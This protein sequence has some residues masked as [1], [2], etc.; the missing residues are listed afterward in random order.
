MHHFITSVYIINRSLFKKLGNGE[1]VPSIPHPTNHG[2]RLY[3]LF[4][5]THN[6]KNVF[7]NWTN[8]TLFRYPT[9]FEDVLHAGG[10][11]DFRHIKALFFKEEAKPLK[12]AYLLNKNSLT[13]N[14]I[15]RTSPKHA[16]GKRRFFQILKFAFNFMYFICSCIQ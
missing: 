16:L 2:K 9:D 12:I 15:A 5:P 10:V 8:K 4:D 14:S 3:M 7:N 13:P 11:A 6:L 1:L